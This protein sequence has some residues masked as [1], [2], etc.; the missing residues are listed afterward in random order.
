S[1]KAGAGGA[2]LMAGLTPALERFGLPAAKEGDAGGAYTSQLEGVPQV[3]LE[4][5]RRRYFDL[6]HTADDTCDKI[7]VDELSQVAQVALEVTRYL[8][9]SAAALSRVP[10]QPKK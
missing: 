4:Q 2:A 9:G 3:E 6:H 8:A 5:D 7:A 1:F 10:P